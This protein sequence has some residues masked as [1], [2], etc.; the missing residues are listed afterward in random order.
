MGLERGQSLGLASSVVEAPAGADAMEFQNLHAVLKA[1]RGR[2]LSRLE[3][4]SVAFCLWR[5]ASVLE[6]FTNS[7]LPRRASTAQ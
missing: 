1:L 3:A 6:S 5:V 2:Q 4:F 7:S